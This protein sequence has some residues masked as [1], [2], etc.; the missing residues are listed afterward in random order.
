MWLN[1][2]QIRRNSIPIVA[3]TANAVS[4]MRELFVEK[5]FNNFLTKPLD[6]SKLDEVLER[7][8]PKSKRERN[9]DAGNAAVSGP[10]LGESFPIIPIIDIAKSTARFGIKREGYLK[11]LSMLR[12]EVEGRLPALTMPKPETL[13]AFV[14]HVHALKGT[15]ASMGAL[16]ISEKAAE[17]EVA[18]NSEDLM[19][20]GE[21]LGFFVERPQ[22][23]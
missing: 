8:I 16:E 12:K 9:K 13:P 22:G 2:S 21:N 3:L 18:G 19:F 6:V 4:G 14:N 7:Q 15:C 5:D 17:L 11:L 1:A 20:I 23:T 10:S